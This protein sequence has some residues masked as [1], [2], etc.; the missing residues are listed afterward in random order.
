MIGNTSR[1]PAGNVPGVSSFCYSLIR[2]QSSSCFTHIHKFI[3]NDST[4]SSSSSPD[5]PFILAADPCCHLFHRN[6][7]KVGF[8][9]HWYVCHGNI[10]GTICLARPGSWVPRPAAFWRR[11]PALRVRGSFLKAANCPFTLANS[12]LSP[13]SSVVLGE[14]GQL[15]GHGYASRAPG[16]SSLVRFGGT[17]PTARSLRSATSSERRRSTETIGAARPAVDT[18]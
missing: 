7:D 5:H 4:L 13:S 16:S 2:P 6:L 14:I 12:C 3:T 8:R 18:H 9:L 10:P 11:P 17:G 1:W 15:R